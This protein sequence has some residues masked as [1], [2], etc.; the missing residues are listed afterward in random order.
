MMMMMMIN[1]IHVSMYLAGANWGH[2]T[3]I[4]DK[5]NRYEISYKLYI[6]LQYAKIIKTILGTRTHIK[7]IPLFRIAHPYCA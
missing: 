4:N 1:F 7:V 5:Y 2:N 6:H 3:K